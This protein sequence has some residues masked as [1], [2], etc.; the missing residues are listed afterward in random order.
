[1]QGT[2]V[3][4]FSNR[5][6][7][8]NLLPPTRE[9]AGKLVLPP[10]EDL[11]DLGQRSL[12]AS[13]WACQEA[14]SLAVGLKDVRVEGVDQRLVES[15]AVPAAMLAITLGMG[16]ESAGGLLRDMLAEA[17]T[18]SQH[19]PDEA[20]L[21]TDI[22]GSTVQLE[23]RRLTVGQAME[24][25]M[26]LQ[27]SNRDAWRTVLESAGVKLDLGVSPRIIFQYQLVRRKL[28]YGTRWAEQ[29]IDQYLRRIDGCECA[30]RRVGG[31]RNRSCLFPLRAF[32]QAYIGDRDS[33][34]E[35]AAG[36]EQGEF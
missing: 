13:L 15:Y 30:I 24:V 8:M 26:D 17:A 1:M 32:V 28:L 12:A 6:V 23:T 16:A 4:P 31:S 35:T 33:D 11:H 9:M 27:A 36:E 7:S 5:A 18:E 20:M 10:A 3:P 21:V 2:C 19:E 34:G 25:A 29:S 22:L 14:R